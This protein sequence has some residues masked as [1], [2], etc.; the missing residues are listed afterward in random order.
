MI[1]IIITT[2]NKISNPHIKGIFSWTGTA[3]S[4]RHILNMA[5][6]I[7]T[8]KKEIKKRN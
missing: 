1:P 7:T 8:I 6:K 4:L 5:D 2:R 3:R